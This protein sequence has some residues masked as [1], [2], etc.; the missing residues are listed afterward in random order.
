MLMS[1]DFASSLSEW[2]QQH[3]RILPWR[4]DPT[5]Y[6]VYLS[7]IMLQQTRVEQA[8]SYYLRFLDAYPTLS[9]LAKADLEDVYKKW[10]G[11]GYYSRA[12]NL[13]LA[14][15]AVVERF[16]GELPRSKADL[17]SLLGIGEYTASAIMAIAYGE[18]EVAID[19]NLLR[20]YARYRALALNPLEEKDKKTA[21]EGLLALL[22]NDPSIFNQA[23]MDLGELVCLPNGSPRCGDCPFKETCLAHREGKETNYPL[24]KAKKE[25]KTEKLTVLLIVHEGKILLQKRGKGLLSGLYGLPTIEGHI[26]EENIKS[27]GD[28]Q[29]FSIQNIIDLGKAKHVFTHRIWDMKGYR[30]EVAEETEGIWADQEELKTR[31]ALPTAFSYF[32]N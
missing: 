28:L 27:V 19:G 16:G 25:K 23:L 8:R 31:Y 14:A 29:G 21:K 20:V 15:K 7:E 5:P 2:Y 6:H 13:H 18:K 22:G 17:L 26:K 32:L 12:R 3:R 11:L 10:E 9:D 4:E 1:M 24:K 30:I